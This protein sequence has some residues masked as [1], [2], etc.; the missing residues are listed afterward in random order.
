[1]G[2]CELK[3]PCSLHTSLPKRHQ[4]HTASES[5]TGHL[6]GP[7]TFL[8]PKA[9]S[10]RVGPPLLPLSVTLTLA[11]PPA[12]RAVR[13]AHDSSPAQCQTGPQQCAM[14]PLLSGSQLTKEFRGAETTQVQPE[15]LAG[16][17]TC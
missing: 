2:T 14:L 12:L 15:G 17:S 3:L 7:R 5:K 1:M 13:W 6:S 11:K 10:F 4:D 8:K 16:K 9:L